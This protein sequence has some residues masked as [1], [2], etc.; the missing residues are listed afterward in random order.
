LKNYTLDGEVEKDRG[1]RGEKG[2][3]TIAWFLRFGLAWGRRCRGG[4]D[5]FQLS[6]SEKGNVNLGEGK[7]TIK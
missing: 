7:L 5:L 6:G 4:A 2:G 3:P 1:F